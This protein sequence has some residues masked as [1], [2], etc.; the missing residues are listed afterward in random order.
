MALDH[1]LY[2]YYGWYLAGKRVGNDGQSILVG[3]L[4]QS[5]KRFDHCDHFPYSAL[6]IIRAH[7]NHLY[8]LFRLLTQPTV[9]FL[10]CKST[11]STEAR[12]ET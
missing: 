1:N 6:H 8:K 3:A 2:Q 9:R 7:T 10:S 11:R 4:F 5:W 12:N